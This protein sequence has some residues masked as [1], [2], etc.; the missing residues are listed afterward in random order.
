MGLVSTGVM[1]DATYHRDGGIPEQCW[2][3]GFNITTVDPYK[4]MVWSLIALGIVVG[5]FILGCI[6]Y[7]VRN[8]YQRPDEYEK[9][10]IR[11]TLGWFLGFL[12]L[13]FVIAMSVNYDSYDRT[14]HKAKCTNYVASVQ[15]RGTY[16]YSEFNSYVNH[17]A[18]AG[19]GSGGTVKIL[20]VSRQPSN[21]PADCWVDNTRATFYSPKEIYIYISIIFGSLACT[22]ILLLL[23]ITCVT[24]GTCGRSPSL[25]L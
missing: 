7:Q 15:M 23:G 16:P 12:L 4:A 10:R 13:A 1:Y 3:D 5:L 14:F 2:S 20:G 22:S 9:D 18:W 6:I 17:V 11:V 21:L 19:T 8:G 25:A 24:C